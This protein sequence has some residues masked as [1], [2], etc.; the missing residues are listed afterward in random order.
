MGSVK[1]QFKSKYKSLI[2]YL[3]HRNSP[4]IKYYYRNHWTPKKGSIA[5]RIDKYSKSHPNLNFIQIGANDGM[6]F[7]PILKFIR[8][9]NWK[10]ILI[11]PQKH[12]F[13]KLSYLHQ[14]TPD[15]VLLN[16]A[17]SSHDGEQ[18][19]YKIAFSESRWA[20]G[21]S[22][23]SKDALL[24]QFDKGY[25]K[26]CMDAEGKT[27][28][29]NESEWIKTEKVRAISFSTLLKEHGIDSLDFLQIDTEGFD[30]EI[31]KMIDFSSFKPGFI[32]FEIAHLS[33]EDKESCKSLL[34]SQGYEIYQKSRD[35]MAE[36]KR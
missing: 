28:P 35:M 30:F 31:I 36:L 5:E 14:N 26:S 19:L 7:D 18:E 9:D 13:E 8:R 23:F 32:N 1:R 34:E 33:E 10:G 4:L 11:E 29:E 6:E 3:N 20:T 24:H 12:V 22:S 21:L 16:A 27:M 2:R 15:V 25:V 17:V